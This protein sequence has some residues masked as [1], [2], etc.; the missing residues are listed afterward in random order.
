MKTIGRHLIAEF[1]DCDVEVLADVERIR[2]AMLEA[3]S[4]VGA[5]V[6]GQV[7]QRYSPQ[8]GVSGAVVISE[9]HLSVHTWPER[10]YVA[11][12]IFTCGGLDPRPG[13]RH[14]GT[15]LGANSCRV[16]EILRG[17]PEELDDH[18]LLLPDDVQIITETGPATALKPEARTP[19]PGSAK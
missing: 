5:T 8:G 1:Y 10:A 16:Q 18:G 12:D 15:A 19:S 2:A 7:F 17:I 3:T 6:V 11:V 13:F 4:L 14:L 9:S